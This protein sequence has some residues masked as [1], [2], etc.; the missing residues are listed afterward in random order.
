[1]QDPQMQDSQ[2]QD[3]TVGLDADPSCSNTVHNIAANEIVSVLDEAAERITAVAG[4]IIG[5]ELTGAKDDQYTFDVAADEAAREVFLQAGLGVFSE[6]LVPHEANRDVVVVLDPIDG[7]SNAARGLPWFSTSMCALD[8]HGMAAALVKNLVNNKTYR[9]V[10]GQGATLDGQALLP[11]T[12]RPRSSRLGPADAV[13][14]GEALVGIT[15]LPPLHLG[16]KQYR[17]M[18]SSALDMCAVAEGITDAYIDCTP[19]GHCTWD[20]LGA[21]LIC[22]EA[23]A[24]LGE[25]WNRPIVPEDLRQRR[26]PVVACTQALLKEALAKR[27]SFGAD[28]LKYT[29]STGA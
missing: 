12:H 4:K 19:Q 27:R 3:P 11:A 24:A 23:G 6:E 8:K 5:P 28:P 20:Y 15:D 17:V 13:Q 21:A 2:M 1:M 22:I 29:L 26:N 16:W 9:A 14:L 10:R 18:G 7:S 25:A